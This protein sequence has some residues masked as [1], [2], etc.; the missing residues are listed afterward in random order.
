MNSD[1]IKAVIRE[2]SRELSI[3]TQELWQMFF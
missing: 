2:M 1:K 3:D